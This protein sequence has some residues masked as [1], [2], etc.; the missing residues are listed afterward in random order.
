MSDGEPCVPFVKLDVTGVDDPLAGLS[1]VAYVAGCPRRC[2]G[3]Q[4]PELQSTHGRTFVPVSI[5]VQHLERLISKGGAD[6]LIEAVVF[7]GGDWMEYP[8]AY[9]GV[10]AWARGRGFRTVL[11]T[12][13]V[14]ERLSEAVRQAS[15]WVIDGTWDRDKKSVYPPSSNQRVFSQG[16]RVDAVE[17][18]PLYKHLL[19]MGS[20][21]AR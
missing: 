9:C 14:Y 20:Q 17:E 6:K 4:N 13:E 11:Y 10:A 16:R 19:E 1:V 3:C 21:S 2:P 5:V 8:A 12:G 7:S 18:L 15:D